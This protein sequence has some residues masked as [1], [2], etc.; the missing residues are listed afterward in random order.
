MAIW[1]E[2]AASG[3]VANGGV[4]KQRIFR[5]SIGAWRRRISLAC[6]ASYRRAGG[7]GGCRAMVLATKPS[8]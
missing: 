3:S 5:V 2:T 8:Q 6:A 4:V 7:A 1:R